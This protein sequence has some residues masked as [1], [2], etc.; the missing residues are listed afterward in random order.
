MSTEPGDGG[1]AH[2]HQRLR[3]CKK[4][5]L[6]EQVEDK[7]YVAVLVDTQT[8]VPPLTTANERYPGTM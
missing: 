8:T 1:S 5:R 3:S 2:M 7:E 6:Q 4:K